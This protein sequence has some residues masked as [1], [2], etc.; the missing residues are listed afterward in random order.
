VKEMTLKKRLTLIWRWSILTAAAVTLFWL[1]WYLIFGQVPTVTSINPIFYPIIPLFFSISRW[2][3]VL[4]MPVYIA[5][6]VLTFT[7]EKVREGEGPVPLLLLFAAAGPAFGLIFSLVS[8]LLCGLVFGLVF[9]KEVHMMAGLAW[10]QWFGLTLGL[11]I[12]VFTGLAIGLNYLC[13]N[14]KRIGNRLLAR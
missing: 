7:S 1:V 9:W 14:W 3:D 4:V 6:L 10:G 13:S 12:S 8:V 2:W 5:V 11:S